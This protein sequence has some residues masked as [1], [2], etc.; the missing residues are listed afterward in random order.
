MLQQCRNEFYAQTDSTGRSM[1]FMNDT[2]V[3]MA[4]TKIRRGLNLVSFSIKISE[5]PVAP[6]L[7]IP[8]RHPNRISACSLRSMVMT[9]A[10][11]AHFL[12]N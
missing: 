9:T 6:P 8:S 1:M 12:K 11:T 3:R 2:Y 5:K 10:E 4:R 7:V